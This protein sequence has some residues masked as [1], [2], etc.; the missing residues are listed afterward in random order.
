MTYFASLKIMFHGCQIIYWD[1]RNEMSPNSNYEKMHGFHG[2]R[3]R[4]S[5]GWGIHTKLINISTTTYP[6]LSTVVSF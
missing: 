4:D 6:G 2:N 5:S 1:A 3:L